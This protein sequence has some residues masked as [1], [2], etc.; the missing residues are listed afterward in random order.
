MTNAKVHLCAQNVSRTK[1]GAFTGE[2]SAEMLKDFGLNYTLIGHSERRHGNA[3]SETNAVVG[4]KT[5]I[6]LNNGLHVLACIGETLEERE[7]N[8]TNAVCVEQIDAFGPKVKDWSQVTIAYEPVWAIGTGK[9]A[10]PEQAQ[11]THKFIRQHLKNT[12]GDQAG[13]TTL[14]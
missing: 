6:A 9:V 14:M 1:S 10:T 7:T 13:N 4:E 11:D 2:H 3:S 12:Y 5:E 8:R